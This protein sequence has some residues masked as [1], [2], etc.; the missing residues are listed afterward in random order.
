MTW[1]AEV[2]DS[3]VQSTTVQREPIHPTEKW[4]WKVFFCAS[5]RDRHY[6]PL[7]TAFDRGCTTPKYLMPALFLGPQMAAVKLMLDQVTGSSYH[8]ESKQ[9]YML[10]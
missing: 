1:T 7:C 3:A 6:A 9:E 4:R 10:E 5:W 2:S 8:P